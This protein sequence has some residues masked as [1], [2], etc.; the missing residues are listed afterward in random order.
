MCVAARGESAV[1]LDGVLQRAVREQ[2]AGAVPGDQQG[3][4]GRV[5]LGPVVGRAGQPRAPHR[6]AL[7]EQHPADAAGA[8]QE[9]VARGEPT[10]DGDRHR[11]APRAARG[12]RAARGVRRRAVRGRA[13]LPQHHRGQVGGHLGVRAEE[14][15]PRR[16]VPGGHH[17]LRDVPQRAG[18]GRA[19]L[20]GVP[21]VVRHSNLIIFSQL[22]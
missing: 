7:L 18:A 8:D 11:H 13:H 10:P 20:R 12:A 15:V 2:Q 19:G 14:R 1:E 21:G 22:C 4:R 3:L 6:H 17:G 9:G 16:A 5:P